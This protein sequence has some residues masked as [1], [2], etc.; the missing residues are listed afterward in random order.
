MPTV[1]RL[2]EFRFFFY[3]GDRDEPQHVHVERGGKVAKVWLQ[4]VRLQRSGGFNRAEIVRI[5][6]MVADHQDRL[7]E[8]WNEYFHGGD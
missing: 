5:Q 4:P 8:A 7:L 2:G 3:A 6:R 1:L